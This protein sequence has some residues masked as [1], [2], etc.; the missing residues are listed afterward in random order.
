MK[1]PKKILFIFL[2]GGGW[3]LG[4]GGVGLEGQ[5]EWEQRSEACVKIQKKIGGEGV[6][7]GQE[8]SGWM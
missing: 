4:S 6:G 8:G 5:G 7:S 2:G 3:G 1:I